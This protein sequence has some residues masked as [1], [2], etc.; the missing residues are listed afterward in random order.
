MVQKLN[1]YKL[2]IK[3]NDQISFIFSTEGY[4]KFFEKYKDG[5]I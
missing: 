2:P 1:Y 3:R 5:I 4:V